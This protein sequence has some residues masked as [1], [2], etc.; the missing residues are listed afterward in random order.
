MKLSATVVAVHILAVWGPCR[1]KDAQPAQR[2]QKVLW[3]Q[4]WERAVRKS[5]L[6]PVQNTFQIQPLVITFNATG[7]VLAPLSPGRGVGC[8]LCLSASSLT[9]LFSTRQPGRCF[10]INQTTSVLLSW[11]PD[12]SS[13]LTPSESHSLYK[14]PLLWPCIPHPYHCPSCS[15]RSRTGL[16]ADPQTHEVHKFPWQGLCT[17]CPHCQERLPPRSL[18]GSLPRFL[19]IFALM[20]PAQW[21]SL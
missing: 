13:H 15:C 11:K 8:R 9:S 12:G 16:L 5:S 18:D 14:D 17:G 10:D 7:V 1:R 2:M 19:Q 4:A 3:D 20:S 6:S 21:G